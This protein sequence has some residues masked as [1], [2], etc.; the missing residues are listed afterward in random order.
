MRR[1][2]YT[3]HLSLPANAVAWWRGEN[4]DDDEG[5]VYNGT[6][7]SNPLF[8]TGHDGQAFNFN[9]DANNRVLLPTINIGSTYSITLW[10]K[11][12]GSGAGSMEILVNDSGSTT[13]FGGVFWDTSNLRLV[14]S[15]NSSTIVVSDN[16][17][18][19]A[20]G[21]PVKITLVY[22][23]SKC[24]LYIQDLLVATEAGTHSETY[25]NPA[26]IGNNVAGSSGH[27]LIGWVDEII[28]YNVALTP[29]AGLAA[30]Y[31]ADGDATDSS[32][33]GW[34]GATGVGTAFD[35]DRNGISNKAF[36][37]NGASNS[38]VTIPKLPLGIAYTY[39]FWLY[40]DASGNAS[41]KDIIGGN[42]NGGTLLGELYINSGKLEYWAGG[43]KRVQ[44]TSTLATT[45]WMEV[46]MTY[47]QV[48]SK[49][50]IYINGTID[51][52]ESGTHTEVVTN[53]P[54]LGFGTG[55]GAAAFSGRLDD[56][57]IYDSVV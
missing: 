40:L 20:G 47:S 15:T 16:G 52:T 19:P 43:S 9:N 41:F 31:K 2:I 3:G 39:D 7:G 10:F 28:L 56:I 55:S 29:A 42:W 5:G 17:S 53:S 57:K 22:S 46:K 51:G 36:K 49:S 35:T 8:T 11:P 32:G 27:P 30:W 44:G 4:N 37:F 38:G 12:G 34:D 23:S 50:R 6:P 21:R 25:N 26:A 1:P 54:V 48:D 14:Y 24:K 18:I 45:T 33:W 13:K